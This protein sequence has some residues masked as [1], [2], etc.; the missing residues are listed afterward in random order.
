M[1]SFSGRPGGNAGGWEI[2]DVD[3]IQI[4]N[5]WRKRVLGGVG[6]FWEVSV[7]GDGGVGGEGVKRHAVR[8][9]IVGFRG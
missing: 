8:W 9:E 6:V 5:R 1:C 7:G 4:E 2:S 3:E